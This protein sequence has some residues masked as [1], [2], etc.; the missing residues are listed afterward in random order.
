MVLA[1]VPPVQT[2]SL[3]F[4]NPYMFSLLPPALLTLGYIYFRARRN[5]LSLRKILEEVTSYGFIRKL[6]TVSKFAVIVIL[7]LLASTPYIERVEIRD[8][9]IEDV[10]LLAEKNIIHIILID[11]SKSMNYLEGGL[12]RIDLAKNVVVNYLRALKAKG[13]ETLIIVFAGDVEVIYEGKVPGAIDKVE[14]I[15]AGEKYTALGDALSYA[16]SYATSSQLPVAVVLVTDGGNN[17]GLEP[18]GIAEAYSRENIPLIIVRVGNDPRGATLGNISSKAKAK[19]FSVDEFTQG[20]IGDLVEE[21][22]REARYQALK[23]RGE[24]YITYRV[25]DYTINSY[26]HIVAIALLLLAIIDGV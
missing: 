24:A 8:V 12:R 18:I 19:I 17:Y 9:S 25:R 3:G 1:M 26:I 11:I 20:A 7:V 4:E 5:I 10:D 14:A 15:E 6:S 16:L 13:D 23:A 2:I 21:I 22:G